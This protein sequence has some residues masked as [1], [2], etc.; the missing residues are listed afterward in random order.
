M[1]Y[2][3]TSGNARVRPRACQAQDLYVR[4]RCC[5]VDQSRGLIGVRAKNGKIECGL[6]IDQWS[7][8]RRL[9]VSHGSSPLVEHRMT[10]VTVEKVCFN[11]HILVQLP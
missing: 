1:G 7:S 8:D 9:K 5:A 2:M 11:C 6:D 3:P 10:L 4:K